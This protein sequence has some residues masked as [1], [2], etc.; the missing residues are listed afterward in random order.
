[1]LYA[2]RLRSTICGTLR[3][4]AQPSNRA[5]CPTAVPLGTRHAARAGTRSLPT[6]GGLRS[7][8]ARSSDRALSERHRTFERPS[9]NRY[10]TIRGCRVAR[11]VVPDSTFF[12][13]SRS[14]VQQ[15]PAPVVTRR[16]VVRKRNL[17]GPLVSG[18][19]TDGDIVVSLSQTS[20][21]VTP[22]VMP[23]AYTGA[24][25]VLCERPSNPGVKRSAKQ[26]SRCRYPHASRCRRPL[27]VKR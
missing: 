27:N 14:V 24:T 22:K 19:S 10:R 9:C 11:A 16:P 4:A 21:A 2:R 20:S 7:I 23:S 6:L 18:L 25:V 26:R 1:M 12:E 3:S 13:D 17:S 8:N 15:C 5:E